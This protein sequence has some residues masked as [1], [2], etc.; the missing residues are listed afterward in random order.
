MS[1]HRSPT[2]DP[3]AHTVENRSQYGRRLH[4]P[5]GAYD[6]PVP[7]CE[8]R[9]RSDVEFRWV[10]TESML[11][12]RDLC[13]NPACFGED[14][15][16]PDGDD[17]GDDDDRDRCP[18][19]GEPEEDRVNVRPSTAVVKP[20][21]CEVALRAVP[22]GG[23]DLTDACPD[24]N[25]SRVT[26]RQ[27]GHPLS[28]LDENAPTWRCRNCGQGFEEPHRRPS[29]KVGG[30]PMPRA[31]LEA[32]PDDIVPDGGLRYTTTDNLE[33]TNHAEDQWHDRTSAPCDVDDAWRDAVPIEHPSA[34]LQSGTYARF[35]EPEGVVMLARGGALLT[36]FEPYEPPS[37]RPGNK[38]GGEV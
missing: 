11:A 27:P 12:F 33:V 2:T 31:L 24:C 23:Q 36:V 21:G 6:R 19:C 10:D 30:E 38:P 16:H 25:S 3:P 4:R 35:Y 8:E 28:N 9:K 5:H 22:D 1:I 26:E 17:D 20:C 15:N 29:V 34:P 14:P 18:E 32:D 13:E 37:T 7:A